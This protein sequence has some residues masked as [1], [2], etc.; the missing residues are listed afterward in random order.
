MTEIS[1]KSI[2]KKKVNIPTQ[3][4]LIISPNHGFSTNCTR[5][6]SS[7]QKCQKGLINALDSHCVRTGAC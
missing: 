7:L 2:E 3:L 4:T 5:L 1:P 6:D